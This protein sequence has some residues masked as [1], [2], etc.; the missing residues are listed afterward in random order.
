MNTFLG[1]MGA[2]LVA[3]AQTTIWAEC[4]LDRMKY[5]LGLAGDITGHPL[6]TLGMKRRGQRS[7][8]FNWKSTISRLTMA[9]PVCITASGNSAWYHNRGRK[10]SKFALKPTV[11][12]LYNHLER[13][14]YWFPI[15]AVMNFPRIWWFKIMLPI[16]VFQHYASNESFHPCLQAWTSIRIF[17][18]ENR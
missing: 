3:L 16:Q 9:T 18:L 14:L 2:F 17:I 5:R 15:A 11:W 6:D 4:M 13:C 7:H 8:V 1:P 12:Q 10:G